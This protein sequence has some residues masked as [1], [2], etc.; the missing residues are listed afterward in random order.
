[1]R[2]I[3]LDLDGVFADFYGGSSRILGADYRTMPPTTAWKILE[4]VPGFFAELPLLPDALA[5]WEG[6]QGAGRLHILTACPRP[7]GFLVSA[8]ADK[9]A[10]VRKHLSVTVP[11]LI[12]RNG[13]AKSRFA[14]T[15]DILI[16]DLPRN[17]SAWESA[18]AL[19]ILHN[20]AHDSLEQLFQLIH[21]PL[22][23][24]VRP[25]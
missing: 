6:V 18:G 2:N 19:G 14:A 11:V 8:A 15:G 12:V 1:M 3:Y 17:V 25:S 22:T 20:N 16:D 21:S 9:L 4:K 13:L 24:D 10:W 23:Q 7:T 5:L